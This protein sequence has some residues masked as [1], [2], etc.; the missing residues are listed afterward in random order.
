[1]IQFSYKITKEKNKISKLGDRILMNVCSKLVLSPTNW[2][3]IVYIQR[4]YK[5]NFIYKI[6]QT[7]KLELE[8]K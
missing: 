3:F 8:K 5:P 6:S 1:M 7:N 2:E 4:I